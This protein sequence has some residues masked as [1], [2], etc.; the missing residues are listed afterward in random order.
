VIRLVF[1]LGGYEPVAPEGMY[2]RFAREL[3]RYEGT[4]SVSASISAEVIGA[5]QA[6]W[7]VSTRGPNWRVDTEYRLVRWD[8]VI[9][10][11]TRRPMWLRIWLGFIAFWDFVA[12]GVLRSYFR[13]N[14]R[15][16]GFFLYPLIL[17]GSFA[18][19]AALAG[20]IVAYVTHSTLAAI[21]TATLG[22]AAL[23]QWLGQPIYLHLLFD[24]WIFSHAYIRGGDPVL[25]ARL[26]GVAHG[27]V[28]AVRDGSAD[29]ITIIGHSLG[30]V[31]AIDV[32][33]R[34]LRLEPL[35]GQSGPQLSLLTI[36]SSIPKIGLHPKAT[37][38]HA[39]MARVAATPGVFWAEYQ[40]INDVM[41]FYKTDPVAELRL[42]KTSG[43][44]IRIVRFREMLDPARYR[45]MRLNFFRLHRQFVSANDRRTPY[46]YFMLVCGPLSVESQVRSPFGAAA[47]IGPDGA[48]L[49]SPREGPA[50][51]RPSHARP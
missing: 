41:N 1:H 9:A 18:A 30:A 12:N 33:D 17:L 35:L 14:W 32:L 39:A 5:D 50:G 40:A 45:R 48:L 20:A 38:F 49:D 21:L 25:D 6:E 4:W 47:T 8:D 2:R 22:L 51:E 29:E 3:R 31:L 44:V 42:P 46:D 16:A 13:T 27:V 11:G 28:R 37:R 26:E 43:P 34:A 7:Q 10:A 15:Y 36:G 19:L 24:D 23:V